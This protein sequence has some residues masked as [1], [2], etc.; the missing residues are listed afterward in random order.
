MHRVVEAELYASSSVFRSKLSIWLRVS[1]IEFLEVA[2]A[3]EVRRHSRVKVIN[4]TLASSASAAYVMR[5]PCFVTY[6]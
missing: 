5:H 1:R 6:Q 3:G 2:V 4:D